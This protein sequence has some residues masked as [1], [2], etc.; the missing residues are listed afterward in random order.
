MWAKGVRR[1]SRTAV[2]ALGFQKRGWRRVFPGTPHKWNT[3]GKEVATSPL[4]SV[5]AA[6][7]HRW[8]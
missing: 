4:S 6:V 7:R 8:D 5:P 3:V 2:A 1:G